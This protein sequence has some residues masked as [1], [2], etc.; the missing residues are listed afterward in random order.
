M[1]NVQTL[2]ARL[3]PI[4]LN[5]YFFKKLVKR[6]ARVRAYAVSYYFFFPQDI[7]CDRSVIVLSGDDILLGDC[8]TVSRVGGQGEDDDVIWTNDHV[9]QCVPR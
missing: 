8:D 2:R 3:C 6:R 9:M 1:V 5:Q 4:D 7:T